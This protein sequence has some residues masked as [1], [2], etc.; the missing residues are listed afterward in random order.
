METIIGDYIGGPLAVHQHAIV[1]DRSHLRL[2]L[3]DRG[4][5]FRA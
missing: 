3:L 5:G 4:L 2:G 1:C